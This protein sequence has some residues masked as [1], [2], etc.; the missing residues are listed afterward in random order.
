MKKFTRRGQLGGLLYLFNIKTDIVKKDD[1][2]VYSP[3]L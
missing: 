3:Q 1:I 2:D